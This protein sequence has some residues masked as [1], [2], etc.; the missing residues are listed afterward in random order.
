MKKI[1]LLLAITMPI[2]VQAQ[3]VYTTKTAKVKFFSH[4]VAE[5]IEAVNNQVVCSINDKTGQVSFA[6]LIKGFKFENSLMQQHFNGKEYMNSG[7]FPKAN[8][9]GSITNITTVNFSKNGTY[10]VSV[11]GTLTLHGISQNIKPTG[12]IVVNKGKISLKSVFSIKP[13]SFG[14]TVP[15]G[16]AETIETTVTSNF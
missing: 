12:T 4:T 7:Q 1:V 16:I 15:D 11:D 5:D 14:V 2:L 13:K 9:V 3:K 10:N 6:V 8:F